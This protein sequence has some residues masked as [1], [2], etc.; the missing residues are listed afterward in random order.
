MTLARLQQCWVLCVASVATL[1]LWHV[2]PYSQVGAVVGAAVISLS[3][4]LVLAAEFILLP[5]LRDADPSPP[6]TPG[7]L[8]TAWLGECITAFRVFYWRQPFRSRAVPD[9]L[10]FEGLPASAR[11]VIFI[12]G[13]VCN[14]GLWT[15]WLKT[16]RAQGRAFAAVDL[17]PV[18]GSIDDYVPLVDDA[19][20]RMTQATGLPP[21]LVCH[22]MGGLVARAWLR[23]HGADDR[24]AHV[25][26]I[27]TPHRGTWLGRFSLSPNGQQM[28]LNSRWLA[29][30]AVQ[31]NPSRR[32]KFTCWYSHCDNIV[33]PASTATLT[34]ADNHHISARAHLQLAFDERVMQGSLAK[35]V[36]V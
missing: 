5:H 4:T 25:I 33:F 12:H 29:D 8:A 6:P 28:R 26:T 19:V 27:G 22:S 7:Q 2:W 32:A 10:S 34:G 14:R 35:I 20:R 1:W 13:F 31:E 36:T 21:V 30:L 11:G 3:Y 24:I 23:A 18:F 17:A 15:P 9:A 16:L